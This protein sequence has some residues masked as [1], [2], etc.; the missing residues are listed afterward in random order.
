VRVDVRMEGGDDG[1]LV[2]SEPPGISCTRS[3]PVCSASFAAGAAIRLRAASTLCGLTWQG[4]CGGNSDCSLDGASDKIVG[5]RIETR[6]PL[7]PVG[8]LD[9]AVAG[10][11]RVTLGNVPI[12]CGRVC[13]AT[14]QA[15]REV[16]LEARPEPGATFL[17]WGGACSGMA[18]CR[19]RFN[20]PPMRVTA[21]FSP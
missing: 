6:C 2:I 15:G 20:Q 5:L 3:T 8:L 18:D 12:D 7:P 16:I 17:G 13:S 14:V 4:G 11:G 9:V 21:A 1:V 10:R 19:F